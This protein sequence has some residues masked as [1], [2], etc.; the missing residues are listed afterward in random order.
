VLSHSSRAKRGL[1]SGCDWGL[2]FQVSALAGLHGS[3]CRA[4]LGLIL[5]LL[6]FAAGMNIHPQQ[7]MFEER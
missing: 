3:T 4:G 5:L 6:V 7:R 2:L 1:R